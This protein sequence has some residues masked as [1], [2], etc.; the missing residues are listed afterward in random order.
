MAE[1]WLYWLEDLGREQNDLVGKKCANLG[2]I[3]KIGL[4]VPHGFALSLDAYNLFMSLT[5]AY[6]EMR[7]CIER[8]QTSLES[9]SGINEL[10]RSLRQIVE[11]KLM[12]AEMTATILLH[13]QGLCDRCCALDV[14]VSA[15]SAGVASHPGQYETHLN[16]KGEADLL[17][18]IK[19]VWSS[20]FNPT[21]LSFRR[22]KGLHLE[23]DPIGVAV[24]KMVNARSAGI[25]FTADPNTGDMGRMIVEANWGLGESV[26]GGESMPDTYV[27]DK[28]TFEVIERRLGSKLRCVLPTEQGVAEQETPKDKSCSF[29]LSDEELAEIARVSIRLEEHFGV[30]QDVEWA[31]DSDLSFPK[32]VILLQTRNEV[33]AK[34]KD[35]V[36]QLL[37]LM[38]TQFVKA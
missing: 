2:E 10:S 28:K 12:P 19:K 26:V 9:I 36:D 27:V 35:P 25:I 21:S 22:K 7:S 4:P 24:L 1:K 17:E 8:P 34:K 33:M 23:S 29:C 38:V 15:R 32:N 6:D 30:P 14:A 20:S 18:K 16:V 31:I 3:A 13:Y 5:G 11:S 37:D